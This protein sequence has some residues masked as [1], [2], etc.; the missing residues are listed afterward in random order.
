MGLFIK[1]TQ[2]KTILISGTD[3]TLNEVYMRVAFS[4]RANGKTIEIAPTVYS[5]KDSYLNNKPLST[6]IQTN[7]YI[8]NILDTENQTIET[9]LSY[10][11]TIYEELGYVVIVEV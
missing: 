2:D 6:D 9:A 1:E 7:N 10:T 5:N 11:K 4:A 8:V 3:I